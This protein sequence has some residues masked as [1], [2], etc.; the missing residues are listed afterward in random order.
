[1]LKIYKDFATSRDGLN[2][3]F[4]VCGKNTQ[5]ILFVHGGCCNRTHWEYQVQYFQKNFQVIIMDLGGHGKSDKNRDVW[6]IEEFAEDVL[7]VVKKLN[8]ENVIL[9]GHS[10]GGYVILEAAI[11]LEQNIAGMIA[12]GQFRDI[13]YISA[14][15]DTEAILKPLKENF[16]QGMKNLFR[17]WLFLPTS[18]SNLVEKI[19]KDMTSVEPHIGIGLL[20]NL[21]SYNKTVL[22][23]GKLQIPVRFI[24]SSLPTT[25][26]DAANRHI[27]DFAIKTMGNTRHFLMLEDPDKF[28]SILADMVDEIISR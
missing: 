11:K 14:K 19:L 16:V 21:W 18:D 5:S 9:V 15:S 23:F 1:M 10:L 26:I 27:K 12:V 24:N 20:E 7:S 13:E 8:L 28:N 25:N 17:P 3:Y 2:I 22:Q 4:E 6:S